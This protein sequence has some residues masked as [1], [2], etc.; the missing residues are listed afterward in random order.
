[1]LL[2]LSLYACIYIYNHTH[3]RIYIY[4]YII[5]YMYTVWIWI[6]PYRDTNSSHRSRLAAILLKRLLQD[7]LDRWKSAA[8]A[9]FHTFTWTEIPS[10][11]NFRQFL[12]H[13]FFN[14]MVGQNTPGIDQRFRPQNKN[15]PG[16]PIRT[17]RFFAVM[18]FGKAA[19]FMVER[20]HTPGPDISIY[21]I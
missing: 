17:S 1:M 21:I 19:L 3:T 18:S 13:V 14:R 11:R 5:Y 6:I 12:F 15:D 9:F 4:V 16:E 20:L 7:A 8:D 10:S 2:S